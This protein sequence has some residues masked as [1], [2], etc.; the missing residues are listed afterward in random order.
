MVTADIF[1]IGSEEAHTLVITT[2]DGVRER[3][4][5]T[6]VGALLGLRRWC[7]GRGLNLSDIS[8]R[9]FS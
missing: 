2:P 5:K 9:F 4:Y 3:D 1:H 6:R 8:L 7:R